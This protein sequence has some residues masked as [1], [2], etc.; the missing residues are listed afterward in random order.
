MI[1]IIKK[2]IREKKIEGYIVSKNDDDAVNE[3]G[4]Y[5]IPDD[6]DRVDQ[7]FD[8]TASTLQNFAIDL[9]K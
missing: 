6:Q 2:I 5:A 8:N 1:K 4:T 7:I 9:C 3:T